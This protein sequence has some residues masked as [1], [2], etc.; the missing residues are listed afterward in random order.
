M[1]LNTY[2]VFSR[3]IRDGKQAWLTSDRVNA[4]SKEA[5]AAKIAKRGDHEVIRVVFCCKWN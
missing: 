3:V 2:E 5:A 4:E 1:D